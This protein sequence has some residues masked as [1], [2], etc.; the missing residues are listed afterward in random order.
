MLHLTTYEMFLMPPTGAICVLHD[1]S[2]SQLI[3]DPSSCPL[4]A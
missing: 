1:G 4:F 2:Q 3:R